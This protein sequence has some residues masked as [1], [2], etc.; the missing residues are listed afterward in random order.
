[1]NCDSWLLPKN[2]R[3]EAMTGLALIRSCGM[4]VVHF[5]FTD[6]FSLIAPLHTN[7]TNAELILQQ[8]AY[9]AHPAVAKVIDVI[10]TPIFL[11]SLSAYLMTA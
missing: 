3:M 4:A 6:I 5:W 1:M 2:S 7:Q 9:G 8:F 10:H 11:V